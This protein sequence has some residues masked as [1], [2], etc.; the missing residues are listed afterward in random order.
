M[1]WGAGHARV[2]RA[3]REVR[4]EYFVPAS[5]RSH[6]GEDTALPIECEQTISQ[7]SLVGQM[8]AELRLTSHSRV[9]EIGTGSGYQT[10]ILAEIAAEVF[11]V[12][13]IP[14][15]ANAAQLRLQ[16]LGYRNIHFR[17][18]D[19]ALGWASHAPFDAII[20]TAAAP[21]LPPALL[22]Q[23]DAGGRMVAPIGSVADDNQVLNLFVKDRTGA[24]AERTLCAV[25]FVPLVS[26]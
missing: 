25:R 12:E 6:A 5:Q 17:T 21:S 22:E 2:L 10:A 19:G 8:T 15:L 23:L 7:P 14:E 1:L 11:T 3:M 24:V 4:R 18:G 16:N 26:D 9:L 20:V 13:R